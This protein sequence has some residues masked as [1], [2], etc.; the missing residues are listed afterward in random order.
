MY[1]I[2]DTMPRFGRGRMRARRWIT[3]LPYFRNFRPVGVSSE[4]VKTIILRLEE[5]EALRLVDAQNLTQEEAAIQMGI[6]RRTLWED[7]RSAR[8]KVARALLNG[9]AIR[10]DCGDHNIVRE[11]M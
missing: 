2:R 4:H 9:Y 3:E 6:S 10:I 5:L 11:E 7:L 8:T 1:T